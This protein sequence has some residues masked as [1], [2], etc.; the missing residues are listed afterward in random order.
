MKSVKFGIKPYDL[1][2]KSI[3]V[4]LK[5]GGRFYF[6]VTGCGPYHMD[7]FDQE[8]LNLRVDVTDIDYIVGDV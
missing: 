6:K 4:Y 8:R 7:G 2:G 1:L 5:S 3:M